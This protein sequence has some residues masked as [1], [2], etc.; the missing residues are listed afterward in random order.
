MK[1]LHFAHYALSG[2][3]VALFVAGCGGSL[4]PIAALGA[5]PSA[6][7]RHTSGSSS[8]LIY[9]ETG[10]GVV[11]ISYPQ[12]SVA[13]SIP[14]YS[15]PS[16]I[17]SDPTNGNVLIP[18]GSTIYEYAHGAT[19]PSGSFAMPTEYQESQGC[20]VDPT[21]GN[22]AVSIYGTTSKGSVSAV[23]I[24][25]AGQST[26]TV[27]SDKTVSVFSY[28][29]YDD[30][31]NLFVS[32]YRRQGGIRIGELK[33]GQDIFSFIKVQNFDGGIQKLQW[34]GMYLAL[35]TT[36]GSVPGT[37]LDQLQI[38]GK[39]ATVVNSIRLSG[40]RGGPLYFWIQS[41]AVFSELRK[42]RK[43]NNQGVG[44]WQYPAGGNPTAQF[45]GITKGRKDSMGDV[46]VSVAPST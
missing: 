15:S 29:A 32:A 22:L 8:E 38:N 42:I 19:S 4:H 9:V 18:E 13:G 45:Y 46:T 30:S 33:P 28:P 26:P 1:G 24:Y 5:A 14:W 37:A 39:S 20:A 7:V 40:S 23:A 6:H 44:A 3:V 34:D 2:C 43:N 41:G 31:G 11:I 36:Y 12:G 27:Y 21:T 25:P 35:S 16:Y 10:A 17:C